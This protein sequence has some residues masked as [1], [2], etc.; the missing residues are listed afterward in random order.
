VY[1]SLAKADA[2]LAQSKGDGKWVAG[3]PSDPR[4]FRGHTIAWEQ[5]RENLA[6]VVDTID[7][8]LI[9]A[10]FDNLEDTDDYVQR[11]TREGVADRG[12]AGFFSTPD[13]ARRVRILQEARLAAL[14]AGLRFRDRIRR[15]RRWRKRLAGLPPG[16]H[17]EGDG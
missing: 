15:K 12:F 1:G 14:K 16:P 3:S 17:L 7:F 10:A 11:K 5:E 13:Y 2:I 8:Q 4:M 9:D 6:R